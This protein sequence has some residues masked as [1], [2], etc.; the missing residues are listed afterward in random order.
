MGTIPIGKLTPTGRSS[1]FFVL[2]VPGDVYQR[3]KCS[4]IRWLTSRSRPRKKLTH[5]RKF[6][7]PDQDSTTP[8]RR[9]P[10]KATVEKN[11]NMKSETHFGKLFGC[12]SP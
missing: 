5:L 6:L 9:R 12:N 4:G 7:A 8:W 11:G 2:L 3:R 10:E 1:G